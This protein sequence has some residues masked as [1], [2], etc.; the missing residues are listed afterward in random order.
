MKEVLKKLEL[1]ALNP[2]AFS[3]EWLD[4]EKELKSTSPIDSA[5]LGTVNTASKEQ[6]ETV[7]A[8]ASEN[9]MRWRELPAPQRGEVVRQIGNEFR[10]LKSELGRL[11]T[12]EMGKILPEGEGEIQEVID[13]ADF[14]VGLSRQLYGKTMHSERF[15]H[16]MY[17]QWHP[18]GN[19]GVITSV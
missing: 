13:I 16:R 10:R 9:F 1:D 4:G 3:G 2:G 15:R 6:Y 11:V 17:E 7:V 5:L 19:V 18:L 14:A 12:L 8:A